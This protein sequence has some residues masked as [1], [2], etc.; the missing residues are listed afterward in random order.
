MDQ[1]GKK[2]GRYSMRKPREETDPGPVET[3]EWSDS[4]RAH[5]ASLVAD[6]PLSAAAT[7][8]LIAMRA[9]ELHRRLTEFDARSLTVDEER[10]QVAMS[11][12]YQ[13]WL[14]AL[15]VAD[16]CDDSVEESL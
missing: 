12:Q 11:R 13:R 15:R 4:D 16:R 2:R 10:I 5:C 6:S 14:E 9:T 7:K 1:E 8:S 3:T